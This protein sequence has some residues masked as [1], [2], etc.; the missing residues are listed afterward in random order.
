MA[1]QPALIFIGGDSPP[2]SVCE[3]LAND[4]YVVAADSGWEHAVALGFMPHLLV[5]DMDSISQQHLHNARDAGTEVLQFDPD[6]DFTD[7]ELALSTVHERGYTDITIISGGGDRFDHLLSMIHSLIPFAVPPNEIVCH[8]AQAR[9]DF[10]SGGYS[11]GLAV[12]VDETISLIPLGGDATGVTTSGLMWNLSNS[13]LS[14]I[15]SRGVSN[16]TTSPVV[17][18]SVATGLLAIIQPFIHIKEQL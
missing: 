4:P 5:G 17:E 7:T 3:H 8:L 14:V 10:V 2:A 16:K 11:I 15:A 9:I 18:I 1:H 13:T 6:K 12:D